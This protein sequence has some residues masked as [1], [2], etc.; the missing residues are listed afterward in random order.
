MTTA[1][2][3]ENLKINYAKPEDLDT[4][5]NAARF[6]LNQAR[7][8]QLA[9][10]ILT[11]GQV[12][13]PVGVVMDGIKRRLLFGFHRH[14]AVAYLNKEQGAGL[15]LPYVVLDRADALAELKTQITENNQRE[16]L[17]PM[18]RAKSMK[19]LL[20]KGVS[21]KDVRIIFAVPGGRK[22]NNFQPM[23]NAM[24]NIHLRFLELPKTFQEKIHSGQLTWAAAYE[25][26]RVTPDKRAA[27]LARAEADLVSQLDKETRDEQ[28]YLD[29][30]KKLI[31]A[32]A[33]TKEV[34][35]ELDKARESISS[36][37]QLLAEKTAA[38]HEVQKEVGSIIT[39]KK[40]DEKAKK[41]AAEKLKAA[42]ADVKGAEKA[43]EASK[44]DVEKLEKRTK[45]VKEKAEEIRE[46]LEAQRKAL[47]SKPKPTVGPTAIK[48]A[49]KAEG[50]T[51]HVP[52]TLQA[53]R[54]FL[55]EGATQTEY[56]KTAKCFTYMRRCCDGVGFPKEAIGN[57]AMLLGE[58]TP[59][60]PV[61]EAQAQAKEG[62][63]KK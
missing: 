6:D 51:G 43:V 40:A 53:I 46:K 37:Q 20:D 17:S 61:A 10:S 12:L 34:A 35:T 26:G 49:A 22:G 50:D 59:A 39:A 29:A 16:E 54:E 30:E 32:E 7:V 13:Q 11:E 19:A 4:G 57:I 33:Q 8:L 15:M 31:E 3:V 21:R 18:D 55:K 9:D 38:Y 45:T 1:G 27:V 47:K 2:A 60:M 42:E 14:A 48:E 5:E 28:K 62:K 63:S 44:A 52:L 56:P 24:L 23:S 36:S 58:R 25:L 41:A